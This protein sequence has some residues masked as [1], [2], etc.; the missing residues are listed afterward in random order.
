MLAG[1]FFKLLNVAKAHGRV[2]GRQLFLMFDFS[3]RLKVEP[4]YCGFRGDT[5]GASGKG[6]DTER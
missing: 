3:F 1:F 5:S 2:E 4:N 6:M